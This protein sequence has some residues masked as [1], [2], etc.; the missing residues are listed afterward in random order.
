M[1]S[2]K[3]LIIEIILISLFLIIFVPVFKN[4]S[5]KQTMAANNMSSVGSLELKETYSGS[6]QLF[7]MT[8]EFA[9]KNIDKTKLNITNKSSISKNYSLL[10]RVEQSS[11][12]DIKNLKYS[13]NNKIYSFTEEIETNDDEYKYY[14]L[15]N[16]SISKS[17]DI[18]FCMWIKQTATNE[19]MNKSLSYSFIIKEN[20]ELA[21]K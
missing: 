5:I 20:N 12:L 14:E 13:I 4:N 19:S 18:E 17:E 2:L 10:L 11:T 8:D 16:S 6:N 1:K 9:I 21:L 7:P 15:I 3:G